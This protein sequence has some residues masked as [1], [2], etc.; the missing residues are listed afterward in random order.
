MV[1]VALI[2]F[3][4]A[5]FGVAQ[6]LNI[7][8]VMVIAGRIDEG[9]TE[10]PSTNE[11]VNSGDFLEGGH[12]TLPEV[13]G[14]VSGIMIQKT[15]HGHGSPYI[16]GF[17]GRQNL[18]LVDGIRVNNSTFRAGPIQYWNTVDP[19]AAAQIEVVK[20]QGSVQFG[21]DAF[22]GTVNTVTRSSGFEDEGE[23]W[24]NHGAAYYRF[25]TNSSSHVGRFET[26]F[27]QGGKWGI[28]LG[29]SAKDYRDIRDSALGTMKNTGYPEQD[30]DLHF[31]MKLNEQTK[32]TIAHHY[33][34]QDDVWRWHNTVFNPGWRHDGHVT[35]PGTDLQRIYD[36]E[37]SL[38]Y[39]RLEGE[40]LSKWAREWE[41]TV[42]WQSSQDSEDRIRGSE[43]RDIKIAEVQTYGLSGQA[44]AEPGYGEL[45]YGVDFYHD[46]VDT[47]GFSNGAPR[48]QNRPVADDATYDNFGVF[49]TYKVTP[50]DSFDITF[51]GR[52]S[53]VRAEWGGYR[54]AGAM[55]DVS[56]ENDWTDLSLS[57]RGLYHV[58]DSAQIY[59]GVSQGFRAPNLDDLTGTQ[60]ALNGLGSKGSPGLDPEEFV[61]MEVGTRFENDTVTGEVAVFYTL[62]DDAIVR[63]PDGG[64]ALVPVNASEGE[65]YGFEARGEWRFAPQW[66]LSGQVWGLD[67]Q[68]ASPTTLGG[69]TR[70]DTI[71]RAPPFTASANLRW[72]SASEQ[73]W[74]EGKVK[75]A[76]EANN[77]SRLE[78]TPGNDDQRIPVNGTPAY[79]IPSLY[80][81]WNVNENVTFTLGLENLTDEDYRVH[82][83]GVNEP[84][85]NAIF[86]ARVGW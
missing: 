25:D 47:R 41:A 21:S 69:P 38:S 83:S 5:A 34:N 1:R 7:P 9:S 22:G 56:G 52:F 59:G 2:L 28:L 62:L 84:G 74:V 17:T 64:G 60:I 85:F 73:F 6:S 67:G 65:G 51:G 12:R 35:T 79:L 81:G 37:R 40:T 48:P 46:D 29:V 26:S 70:T 27:G 4:G 42:S 57:V 44:S 45:L 32:L 53:Y 72:T 16:R 36:Q 39:G 66:E 76:A 13:L 15:T 82:G 14:N 11:V 77:L 43:R 55:A 24:F 61:S 63:V 10:V 31:D 50:V 80:G 49:G 68:V 23:G 3:F 30:Y 19:Y 78:K 20:G 75:A 71:R 58:N 54:P 8:E 18:L 86:G 33:V